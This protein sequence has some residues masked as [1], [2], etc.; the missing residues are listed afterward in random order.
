MPRPAVQAVRNRTSPR[1]WRTATTSA[2]WS[3]PSPTNPS[4]VVPVTFAAP[5][6]CAARGRPLAP[7]P[8]GPGPEGTRRACGCR[9]G[10]RPATWP[11]GEGFRRGRGRRVTT[12]A[13]QPGEGDR[14][15]V[16]VAELLRQGEDVLQQQLRGLVVALGLEHVGEG[17]EP[18]EVPLLAFLE[19]L[20]RRPSTRRAPPVPGVRGPRATRRRPT[21]SHRRLRPRRGG[22]SRVPRAPVPASVDIVGPGRR[23]RSSGSV[24]APV[25]VRPRRA[26]RRPRR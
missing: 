7:W 2:S 6:S 8:G 14:L 22:S 16:L 10:S 9:R 24:Q 4:S 17:P 18:V 5:S 25:L 12:H 11:L 20:H 26:G 21:R 15:A 19:R 3:P 13:R 23:A 1:P